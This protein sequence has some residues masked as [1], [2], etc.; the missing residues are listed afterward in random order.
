MADKLEYCIFNFELVDIQEKA[1]FRQYFCS[2]N[3]FKRNTLQK[4][5]FWRQLWESTGR[6]IKLLA[7]KY[8]TNSH[9]NSNIA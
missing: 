4:L 9:G 5:L 8:L 3:R 7:D 1:N 6:K 2:R